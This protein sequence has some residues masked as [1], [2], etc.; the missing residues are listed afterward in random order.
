MNYVELG[1][2]PFIFD[3]DRWLIL[4]RLPEEDKANLLA[5]SKCMH[6]VFGSDDIHGTLIVIGG[7]IDLNKNMPRKDIDLICVLEA[8]L[9]TEVQGS[10]ASVRVVTAEYKIFRQL[11]EKATNKCG[12]SV[13]DEVFPGGDTASGT[14]DLLGRR[15]SV[16]VQPENGTPIDVILSEMV[17]LQE[18]KHAEKFTKQKHVIFARF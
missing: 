8:P 15:G 7:V 10:R 5:L 3:R 14:E 11:M 16:V 18:F 2:F 4:R 12:F 9:Q 6:L 13:A 1:V 17:G